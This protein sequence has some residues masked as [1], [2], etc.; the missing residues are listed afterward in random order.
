M[1]G[2]ANKRT[3]FLPPFSVKNF[4]N[5][6]LPAG[7]SRWFSKNFKQ[8]WRTLSSSPLI[9][10]KSQHELFFDACDR[11]NI[12]TTTIPLGIFPVFTCLHWNNL[13]LCCNIWKSLVGTFVT[14]IPQNLQLR[15][16]VRLITWPKRDATN[17]NFNESLIDETGVS[18]EVMLIFKLVMQ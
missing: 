11:K 18:L 4:S 1:L 16:L 8:S 5:P 10:R 2:T 15:A 7:F 13:L 3:H 17:M 12:H 14:Q 9:W 6:T